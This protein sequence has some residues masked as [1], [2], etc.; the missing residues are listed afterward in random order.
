MLRKKTLSV[1][2]GSVVLLTGL[3]VYIAVGSLGNSE[4]GAQS[5]Q[6]EAVSTAGVEMNPSGE[7][8]P[9]GEKVKTPLSEN[10]MRQYIHAMSHQK[11]RAK[12]KWSF[13]KITDERINYLL[14]Q[15]KINKYED[16]YVYEDILTAW[17]EGDY[18]GVVGDHNTIWRLQDGNIGKATSPLNAEQEKKYIESQ[19]RE[20]R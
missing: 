7:E 4:T 18:S 14:D 13:F 2:V 9:F 11:V 6:S 12:E 3:G 5:S 17:K 20:K 19:K 10:L 8:N 15:L 1:I 16:E